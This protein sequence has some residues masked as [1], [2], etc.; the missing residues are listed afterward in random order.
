M[1]HIYEILI[2]NLSSA[3]EPYLVKILCELQAKCIFSLTT[4]PPSN[5][6]LIYLYII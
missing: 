5:N 4:L 6:Q 1:L 3:Y 2:T